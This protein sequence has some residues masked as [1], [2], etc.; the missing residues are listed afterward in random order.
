MLLK[1]NFD[2]SIIAFFCFCVNVYDCVFGIYISID[3]YET[4]GKL[5]K[6]T[7]GI[8]SCFEPPRPFLYS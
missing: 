6:L 1:L 2:V 3:T 4:I 5:E 8:Q 7:C